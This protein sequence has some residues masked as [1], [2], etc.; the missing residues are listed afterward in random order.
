MQ[1]TA[2]LRRLLAATGVVFGSLLTASIACAQTSPA[3][4]DSTGQLTS[5]YKG[6]FPCA[7]EKSLDSK[8]AKAGDA[9]VC[10][11]AKAF[12]DQS[13]GLIPSG[14]KISGHVTQAQARSKGDANST[15]AL[16]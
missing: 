10:Q 1:R 5:Q 13:G 12:R 16:S 15:L 14:T 2:I 11:T 4:S 8:K 6:T 7:L 9:V 3:T